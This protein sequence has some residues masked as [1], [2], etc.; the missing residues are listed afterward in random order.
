MSDTSAAAKGARF[1]VTQTMAT[2]CGQR[3]TYFTVRRVKGFG[4]FVLS[5]S[6]P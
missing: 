3:I 4:K 6:R 2:V 5:V 1:R